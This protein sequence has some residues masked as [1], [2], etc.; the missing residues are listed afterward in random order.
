MRQLWTLGIRDTKLHQIIKQMLKAPIQMPDKSIVHPSRGT[1]QG[2]ILSPLLANVA[3]NELDWLISSQWKNKWQNMKSPPKQQYSK[4]NRHR[5]L[6]NECKALRK[7]KLKE[8]YIV[9]YAD[10][11]KI[12]CRTRQDAIKIKMAVKGW[13][14]HRLKC[15]YRKKKQV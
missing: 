14:S 12:F 13:L 5:N 4:R 9:R 2:G 3:L 1:P 15:R 10:D 8:M 6:G 7:T 11:F